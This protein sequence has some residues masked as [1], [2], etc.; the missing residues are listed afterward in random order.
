MNVQDD[1]T[2]RSYVWN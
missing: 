2:V 1:C